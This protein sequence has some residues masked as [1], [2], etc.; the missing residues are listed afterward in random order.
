ML[1]QAGSLLLDKLGDHVAK[2][3]AHGVEPLVGGADIVKT[4]VV[5]EDF[6]DDEDGHCFTELRPS[7]HNTETQG[8]DFG[9]EEEVDNFRGVVLNQ[10]PDN[11]KRRQSQIFERPRL[12]C[13]IEERIEEERNMCC[14]VPRSAE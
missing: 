7:L 9:G 2:H 11:P 5:K 6:L 12:G 10:S 4:T 8:N 1:Q 13:R 3:S 14:T